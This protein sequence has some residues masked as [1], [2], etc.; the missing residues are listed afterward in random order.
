MHPLQVSSTISMLTVRPS[1]VSNQNQLKQ[2]LMD[3]WVKPLT[4]VSLSE[5]GVRRAFKR[6]NTKKAAGPDGVSECVLKLCADQL[7][8]VFT[9]IF[10]LLE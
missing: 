9:A 7:A 3:V 2:R 6:V 1:V 5:H 4:P 8:P 10:N